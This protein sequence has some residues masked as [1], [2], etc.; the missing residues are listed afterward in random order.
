MAAENGGLVEL[1]HLNGDAAEGGEQA[2]PSV[3]DDG[4]DAAMALCNSL[5]A[6]W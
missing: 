2:A 3:A 1:A 6:D 4:E 5:T